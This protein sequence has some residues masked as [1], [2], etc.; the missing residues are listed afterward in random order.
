MFQSSQLSLCSLCHISSARTWVWFSMFWHC[1]EQPGFLGNSLSPCLLQ[2]LIVISVSG[3]PR[4]Y[5]LS[6]PFRLSF[7]DLVI[8]LGWDGSPSPI[9]SLHCSATQKGSLVP[10]SSPPIP[11]LVQRHLLVIEILLKP[12]PIK[13]SLITLTIYVTYFILEE[14]IKPQIT[15]H[16]A[17]KRQVIIITF[18]LLWQGN[19][20]NL[21]LGQQSGVFAKPPRWVQCCAVSHV[22]QKI[23]FWGV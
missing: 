8:P 11:S 5:T 6:Y 14:L 20:G 2:K 4:A 19:W 21:F 17:P 15:V 22:G 23:F 7:K 1:F 16:S 3:W 18:S 13:L 12:L 9:L 10:Q